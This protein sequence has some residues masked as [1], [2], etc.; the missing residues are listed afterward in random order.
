MLF[1]VQ[2]G[3]MRGRLTPLLNNFSEGGSNNGVILCFQTY[4]CILM[5]CCGD[6]TR[7]IRRNGERLL[8]IFIT[9][10]EF[11]ADLLVLVHARFTRRIL[12]ATLYGNSFAMGFH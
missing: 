7:L 2:H 6:H 9:A 1:Q 5:N 12:W 4:Y 11:T 8:N 10:T 3:K